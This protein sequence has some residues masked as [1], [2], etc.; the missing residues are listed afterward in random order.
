MTCILAY[1][2][3]K[4]GHSICL[5]G[6]CSGSPLQSSTL[7]KAICTCL[8]TDKLYY[9]GS[10]VGNCPYRSS[11]M[12]WQITFQIYFTIINMTWKVCTSLCCCTSHFSCSNHHFSCSTKGCPIKQC[13]C[14]WCKPVPKVWDWV[15]FFTMDFFLHIRLSQWFNTVRGHG[16]KESTPV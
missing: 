10:Q 12:Y 11:I 15:T 5:F 16:L 6:V 13:G 3:E 2:I 4:I 9:E 14:T 8:I 7:K 1:D